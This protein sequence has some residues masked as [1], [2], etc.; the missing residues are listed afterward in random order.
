VPGGWGGGL[1]LDHGVPTMYLTDTSRRIEAVA[2]L[3]QRSRRSHPGPR[4]THPGR[5]LEFR[6]VIDWYRYLNPRLV[7]VSLAFTGI[8]E[9]G[10]RIVYTLTTEAAG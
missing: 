5:S 7:N 10:N 3:N 2:A 9:V 4:C 6:T 8:D 1:F